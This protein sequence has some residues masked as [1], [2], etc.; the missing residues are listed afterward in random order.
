MKL[1][2]NALPV[3]VHMD[4]NIPPS[5]HLAAHLQNALRESLTQYVLQGVAVPRLQLYRTILVTPLGVAPS[6]AKLF[7]SHVFLTLAKLQRKCLT[8]LLVCEHPFAAHRRRFLHDGTPP[9]WW[10]C[11]FCR[12]VRCVEDEGHVLFECVNDGLIKARTRAF[13]DML[14]IHPPLEYVL[15]KRT[16]V[17]DLVRFF[18]RHPPLLARFADFVHTTFKMC[19]EVPMIIITSQN[20]LAELSPR[21]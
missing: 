16:D 17:W 18:A 20:D 14:T 9:D 4:I 8:R 5:T 21:P 1:A 3:P 2:F 13:R 12:D 11:R 7:A 19:D 10:I 6:L 15:P